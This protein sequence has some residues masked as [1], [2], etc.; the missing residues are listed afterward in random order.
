MQYVNVHPGKGPYFAPIYRVIYAFS[1]KKPGKF[2]S[3]I[4]QFVHFHVKDRV[5]G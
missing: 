4:A 5:F 3:I 1:A 2:S